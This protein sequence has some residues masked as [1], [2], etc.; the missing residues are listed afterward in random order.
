MEKLK[1]EYEKPNG[2]K[3][4]YFII[5]QI[6]DRPI[7]HSNINDIDFGQSAVMHLHILDKFKRKSGLGT[8]LLERTLPFYFENFKL[9]KLICEPK[10][11][12]IPPNKTLKKIGFELVKTYETIPGWLNF[13]QTVN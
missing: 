2:Q 3:D 12:N 13:K 4:F 10:A 6:D 11:E 5:W 7:G 1:S 9:K 8:E